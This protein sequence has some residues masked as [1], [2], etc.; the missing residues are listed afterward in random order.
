MLADAW[1]V[2]RKELLELTSDRRGFFGPLVQG[3]LVIGLCGIFVPATKHSIWDDPS[4]VSALF[5]IF[6]ALLAGPVGADLFAG[7][8]ERCTLETLLATPL[9]DDAIFIGKCAS[10]VTFSFMVA[11]VTLVAAV[12]TTN[13]TTHPFALFLPDKTL[14]LGVLCGTLGSA[15]LT[16]AITVFVSVR[17]TTSRV[18]QQVSN[19]CAIVVI[20]F[21]CVLMQ[22]LSIDYAFGTILFVD[23]IVT[24]LGLTA[25]VAASDTFERDRIFERR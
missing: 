1:T 20:A 2:L 25:L 7:E 3:L 5:F 18:A 17:V 15:L 14:C 19:V 12:V 9:S 24:G 22:L 11:L 21:A 6:P 4:D 10:A 13:L 16:T 23:L 8:R